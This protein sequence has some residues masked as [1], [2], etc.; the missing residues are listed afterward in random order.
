MSGERWLRYVL[1]VDVW[2]GDRPGSKE[3]DLMAAAVRFGGRLTRAAYE[4]D[5]RG[6]VGTRRDLWGARL[7]GRRKLVDR[8]K[9]LPRG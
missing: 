7:L 2:E 4:V 9:V 1:T 6:E 5:D 8:G 3:A